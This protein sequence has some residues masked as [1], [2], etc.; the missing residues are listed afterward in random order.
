MRG[1][2]TGMPSRH[3]LA[4]MLPAVYADDAFTGRFL[5]GL[6]EVVAP[7]FAALD[8]FEAYLDPALAPEDF[9]DWLASWVAL[10]LQEGWSVDRR[11]RIVAIAVA[12]HRRRGTRAGLA[13]LIETVTGGR[14]EIVDS[15]G[16]VASAE[17]G[18]VLP[19]PEQPI[20]HVRVYVSD[21]GAVR[22]GRVDALVAENKPVHM[23]H[24]LEI[25]PEEGAA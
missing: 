22:H 13:G 6:D 20:L 15:G 4:D 18:G 3:P 14:V 11:R 9:L 23:P 5:A 25:L 1:T 24:T 19:G 16:C 8:C 12:L 10:P 17:P 7:V 2:V 21:P